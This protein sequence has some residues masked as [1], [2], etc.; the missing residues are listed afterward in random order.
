MPSDFWFR[1]STYLSLALASACLGYAEYDLL[2][3]VAVFAGVVIVLLVVS[4]F[5][6]RRFELSLGKANLVGLVIGILATVWMAANLAN[7]RKEGPMSVVEWPNNLPPIVA[8]LL[9]VLIPAKLFRPKHI[10]DWWAMHG[11]AVTGVA[12]AA[13]M[14]D[15]IWFVLLLLGYCICATWSLILFFYRRSGS[16]IAPIPNQPVT[17]PSQILSATFDERPP[18]HVLARS[19]LWLGLAAC[20]A[21]PLYLVLPKGEESW[22]LVKKK[23]EIGLSKEGEV[24]M[25]S[26]GELKPTDEVAFY[27]TVTNISGQ[28]VHELPLD[29]HFRGRALTFYNTNTKYQWKPSPLQISLPMLGLAP[30]RT[31]PPLAT[32]G[33]DTLRIEYNPEKK[34]RL[35][36]LAAPVLVSPQHTTVIGTNGAP[37]FKT[38]DFASLG[39]NIAEFGSYTQLYSPSLTD[40]GLPLE[41]QNLAK[42]RTAILN[43]TQLSEQ[44]Y[45]QFA[46]KLLDDMIASGKLP[47]TVKTV[48][49]PAEF[50]RPDDHEAVARAFSDYFATSGQY[51]Y[52]TTLKIKDR[53]ID[54]VVDFLKNTR[55]GHCER[56][57]S[58]LV[59]VLRALRIPCQYV[60]GYRGCEQDEE[61]N[62]LIR[63]NAAHAWVE[64]F[65]RRAPPAGYQF[66]AATPEDCKSHVY[67]WMMLDPTTG[68]GGTTAV[69]KNWWD[70]MGSYIAALF[71]GYDK[72]RREKVL[73]DLKKLAITVGPVAFV[74]LVGLVVGLVAWNRRK[75]AA[76]AEVVALPWYAVYLQV[77]ADVG[78]HPVESET[79]KETAARFTDVLEQK[80]HPAAHLPTFVVSKLYR[81]RYAGQELTTEEIQQIDTAITQLAQTVTAEAMKS[82]EGI[83]T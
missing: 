18:K 79:P 56:F 68:G 48:N 33:P 52:S 14:S 43:Y 76:A 31:L 10:G 60:S 71:V 83:S 47:A 63:R 8:P 11:V 30:A 51:D 23:Y 34:E 2:P 16:L 78:L 46:Y 82:T 20:L 6:D 26:T 9:L 53:S 70:Q 64:V 65:I 80:N 5:L 40:V 36:V 57:A 7:P 74:A 44:F 39:T 50:I 21:M 61:G 49:D 24:D 75:K 38:G 28:Q 13:A 25:K 55:T 59:L 19:F 17:P 81:S 62:F 69:K 3:E 29:L 22:S 73:G 32:F 37:W 54:P 4:F 35:G 66:D 77:F 58:A 42:L 27:L 1:L 72:D 15:D 67:H 12:L 41:C 45:Q